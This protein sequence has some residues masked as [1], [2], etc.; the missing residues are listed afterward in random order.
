[1]SI[2]V[3]GF[4]EARELLASLSGEFKKAG[5]YAQNAT[6]YDVMM[7]LRDQIKIDLDNPRP[8]SINAIAYK[9]SG[10]ELAGYDLGVDGAAVFIKDTFRP[11]KAVNAENYLGVQ[12]LGGLAAGPKRSERRLQMYGFMPRDTVWVP[13]FDAPR[14]ASNDLSGAIISDMLT[15]LGANEYGRSPNTQ[16][17]YA[18]VYKHGRPEGV[19][20]KHQGYWVPF[21]WFVPIPAYRKRFKF[22]ER[23]EET[24]K[25]KLPGYIQHYVDIAIARRRR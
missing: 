24:V 3:S 9:K 16:A 2:R 4:E 5:E 6:A 23:A 18:L 25:Q 19:Y 8:W 15:N 13:A 7:S 10:T 1:M 20:R 11:G 17:K 22:Y 21:L 12:I 14:D